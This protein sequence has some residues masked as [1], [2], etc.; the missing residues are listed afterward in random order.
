MAALGLLATLIPQLMP[1]LATMDRNVL[2]V[3]PASSCE[4]VARDLQF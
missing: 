4:N 3:T 2:P 1:L